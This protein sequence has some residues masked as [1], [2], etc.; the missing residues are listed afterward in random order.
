M[1]VVGAL[2]RSAF[3][4]DAVYAEAARDHGITS[5]Q[6]QLLCVLMARP[7]GMGE[8]GPMLRL[9][10]SSL[11]G[12]VDRTARRGLVRREPDPEDGRAVRLALTD[13]GARVADAFYTDACTRIDALTSNLPPADREAL[14][15]LLG[16]VVMENKVPELFGE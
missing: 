7:R 6:G 5:Q 8:L 2:V 11:T 1:G 12:L 3:L 16:R 13:E 14:A 4:T 15:A 10:K 9:A